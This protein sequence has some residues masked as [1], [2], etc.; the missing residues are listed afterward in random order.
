MPGTAPSRARLRE[1]G[2]R[3]AASYPRPE[4]RPAREPAP[5]PEREPA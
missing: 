2:E 5:Q 4:R 1:Q 3:I